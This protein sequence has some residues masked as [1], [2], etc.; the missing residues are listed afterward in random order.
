LVQAFATFFKPE[1][2]IFDLDF[3][4]HGWLDRK[5]KEGRG[6]GVGEEGEEDL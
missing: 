6:A 1:V 3:K 5:G 2:F 4:K